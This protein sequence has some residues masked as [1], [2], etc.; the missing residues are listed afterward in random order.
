M[1]ETEPHWVWLGG[2]SVPSEAYAGVLR[3]RLSGAT[4]SWLEPVPGAIDELKTHAVEGRASVVA[5]YSLGSHLILEALETGWEPGVRVRLFAPVTTFVCRVPGEDPSRVQ[6][7]QLRAFQRLLRAD[8]AAAVANFDAFA[9]LSIPAASRA[10][11]LES[12]DVDEL[13]WGLEKLAESRLSPSIFNGMRD[14]GVDLS[15]VVGA[16]DALIAGQLLEGLPAVTITDGVGHDL[17]DLLRAS[18]EV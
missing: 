7:K 13:A 1:L 2:W 4:H 14:R 11:W 8:P 5:G 16:E 18:T 6:P 17:G 10:S 3:E 12:A 15:A 9:G